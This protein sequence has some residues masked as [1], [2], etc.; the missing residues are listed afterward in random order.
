M[1]SSDGEAEFREEF[2]R[3]ILLLLNTEDLRDLY[4]VVFERPAPETTV[5]GEQRGVPRH[6]AADM[7]LQIAKHSKLD[8]DRFFGRKKITK[9]LLFHYLEKVARV[10][11]GIHVGHPR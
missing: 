1:A 4:Q 3:D 10:P 9:D 7:A 8:V 2:L 5:D 6:N 11:W